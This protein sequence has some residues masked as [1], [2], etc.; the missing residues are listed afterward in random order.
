[1]ARWTIP[2]VG[3]AATVALVAW[4]ALSCAQLGVA[5]T[6]TSG[7]PLRLLVNTQY[8]VVLRPAGAN[9]YTIG[10][11]QDRFPGIPAEFSGG[12]AAV[13]VATGTG[14]DN[15]VTL[16]ADGVGS[17]RISA[18][19]RGTGGV[20]ATLDVQ[21]VDKATAANE[22]A[23]E[24]CPMKDETP[25][26]RD[27]P[28]SGMI[29]A[30]H[31]MHDCQRLIKDN[32]YSALVGIFAH[33]NLIADERSAFT[34]GRLAAVIVNFVDG[35]PEQSYDILGIG[36]G[37]NCLVIR[38][39][40]TAWEAAVVKRP[41]P[42]GAQ[43]A[44]CP[45]GMTWSDVG[46]TA[47]ILKVVART[48]YDP[49]NTTTAPPAA[50]WDTD[51]RRTINTIGVKC[52]K[53]TWCDILPFQDTP[54][55][56]LMNAQGNPLL[57]GYYDE[58]LLANVAADAPTTVFGTIRPGPHNTPGHAHND[59]F[60]RDTIADLVIE[61][62]GSGPS[63]DYQRYYK[64]FVDPTATTFPPRASSTLEITPVA[65]MHPQHMFSAFFNRQSLKDGVIYRRHTHI[66]APSPNPPART[67][68]WRWDV[69]DESTWTFCSPDG[70]CEGVKTLTDQ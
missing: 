12:N 48:G 51:D 4:A 24:I 57:K 50:R 2:A 3:R 19:R 1:M 32:A 11:A 66:H 25:I 37:T 21:V 60:R 54:S 16:V 40:T 5:P 49:Q 8:E 62:T 22:M 46:G 70:C 6:T 23:L 14:T 38:A 20:D 55:A 41:A 59:P 53:S 33:D 42:T 52:G 67:A 26:R 61:E 56:P 45:D 30:E 47:K 64:G 10:N 39:T 68:R 18:V 63:L 28:L 7:P 35:K 34:N 43:Y 31:G 65:S 17:A 27:K 15:R 69:K 9:Q 36:P 58:Q 13:R 44:S 29:A